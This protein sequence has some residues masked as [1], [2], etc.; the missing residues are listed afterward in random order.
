MIAEGEINRLKELPKEYDVELFN[1]YYKSMTPLI[2]KLAKN[3]DPRRFNVSRD[4]II[5]YFYDK[6]LYV[7]RKYYNLSTENPEK[8][9]ATIISSLQLYKTRLLINAYSKQSLDFNVAIA[10]FEDCFEGAK[11]DLSDLSEDERVKQERISEIHEFMRANLS[12]DAYLLFHLQMSPPPF[13]YS[14]ESKPRLTTSSL[15]DF[16]ELPKTK[17]YIKYIS[18]LNKEIHEAIEDMKETWG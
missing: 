8:F 5:S 16:F 14:E 4:I 9:K 6:L 13:F 15:L 12:A 3:I 1:F 17:L 11:E 10:S 7:F 18:T 2:R